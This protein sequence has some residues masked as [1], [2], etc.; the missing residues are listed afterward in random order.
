MRTDLSGRGIVNILVADQLTLKPLLYVSLLLWL[1][2][3][4]FE[5]LPEVG[6]LDKP[7]LAFFFDE[8]HL[9][10]DDVPP[11]QRQRVEQ[12][13]RIIRAKGVGVYFCSQFPDDMP[14][15]IVG[16]LGVGEALVS[17][18]QEKGVPLPVER[19]LVCP[20]RVFAPSPSRSGAGSWASCC[21]APSAGRAWWRA[22]PSRPPAPSAASAVRF[23]PA[24]PRTGSAWCR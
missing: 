2:S 10:F 7:K 20:P 22:W 15:E 18:L 23:P 21:G 8:A 11:A 12:V 9:L 3:E 1:L 24:P 19:T 16:Q 5:N 6:E 4:L 14:N 17:T 13:V